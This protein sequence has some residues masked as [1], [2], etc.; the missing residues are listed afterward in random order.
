MR[1]NFLFICLLI[2]FCGCSQSKIN[3]KYKYTNE[4]E[5]IQSFL[6]GN[7]LYILNF[8]KDIV[9]KD[10]AYFSLYKFDLISK[11]ILKK[12]KIKNGSILKNLIFTENNNSIIIINTATLESDVT[13]YHISKDLQHQEKINLTIIEHIQKYNLENFIDLKQNLIYQSI[14][15]TKFIGFPFIDNNTFYS[16]NN[17]HSQKNIKLTRKS[18]KISYERD[19]P[20][21]NF[22]GYEND[23]REYSKFRNLNNFYLSENKL[24]IFPN[25][26]MFSINAWESNMIIFNK[27]NGDLEKIKKISE[28]QKF[29]DCDKI[30]TFDSRQFQMSSENGKKLIQFGVDKNENFC[31]CNS[32]VID[33]NFYTINIINYNNHKI[34]I[35]KNTESNTT[36]IIY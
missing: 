26:E 11:N 35:G 32:K 20:Y 10:S 28:I 17:S 19:Y 5:F 2:F 16:F 22:E 24:F 7:N 25:L 12:V 21:K 27:A 33:E 8:E 23:F 9:L 30:K 15:P 14:H 3:L 6:S 1:K 29:N 31:L 18:A 36:Q 4:S 34:Y 13:S